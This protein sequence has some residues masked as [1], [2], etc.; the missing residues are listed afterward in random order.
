MLQKVKANLDA[1]NMTKKNLSKITKLVSRLYQNILNG[2][3]F[4]TYLVELRDA[5]RQEM[6]PLFK[7]KTFMEKYLDYINKKIVTV[8]IQL[9]EPG[10]MM[11][12]AEYM[13]LLINY[14]VYRRLFGIE[15]S[16]IYQKIW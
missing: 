4:S 16:K 13:N 1:F 14:A 6:E 7:N 15:D 9:Q 2:E 10:N 11:S 5:I 3:L 12:H 8:T